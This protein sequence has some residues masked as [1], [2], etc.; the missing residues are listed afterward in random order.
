MKGHK[1][2]RTLNQ[3]L[4]FITSLPKN[5]AEINFLINSQHIE[6]NDITVFLKHWYIYREHANK[7]L[8]LLNTWS[9]RR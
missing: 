9:D 5:T 6:V 1:T 7:L 8:T 4:H 2:Y 3:T